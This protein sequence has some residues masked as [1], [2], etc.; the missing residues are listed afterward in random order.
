M[1]K[2]IREEEK[3]IQEEEKRIKELEEVIKKH[4]KECACEGAKTYEEKRKCRAECKSRKHH[5]KRVLADHVSKPSTCEQKAIAVCGDIH[6][7]ECVEC[8]ENFIVLCVE[9]EAKRKDN[10]VNLLE[11]CD[12]H[13]DYQQGIKYQE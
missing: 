5:L 1:K 12:E 8:Q 3:R 2:K 11:E 6:T 4:G 7:D 9:E 13:F 10:L